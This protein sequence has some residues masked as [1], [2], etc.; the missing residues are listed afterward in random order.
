MRPKSRAWLW[1]AL[2]AAGVAY[3]AVVVIRELRSGNEIEWPPPWALIVSFAL[4][5]TG[6]WLSSVA[7]L[8]LLDVEAR[9]RVHRADFFAAQLG[10][11]LPGG[12]WQPLGQVG[13][14]GERGISKA[15]SSG[16]IVAHAALQVS[17][18][19]ALAFPFAFRADLE[20]GW[21]AAAGLSL[22]GPILVYPALRLLGRW[23]RAQDSVRALGSPARASITA[24][25]LLANIAFQGVAFSLLASVDRGDLLSTTA[26]FSVAWTLGFLAIPFPAGLGVREAA[27]LALVPVQAATI[28]AASVAGR[29]VTVAVE[30]SLILATRFRA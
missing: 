24:G 1:R 27:L 7:W 17:V 29:I 25:L 30:F 12:V 10:K 3:M 9:E 8:R 6:L 18:G 15:R 5:A 14:A 26:A 16:A 22:L 28:V 2:G 23:P 13:L 19:L 21:R 20:P 11:Y 4:I